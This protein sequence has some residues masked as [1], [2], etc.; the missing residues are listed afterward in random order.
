MHDRRRLSDIGLWEVD[1]ADDSV[2]KIYLRLKYTTENIV[3]LF[4]NV[5]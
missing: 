3:S 5:A 1:V 2:T 4:M